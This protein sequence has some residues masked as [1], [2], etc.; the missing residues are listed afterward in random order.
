MIKTL[1]LALV[2]SIPSAAFAAGSDS[3]NDSPPAK[4]KTSKKCK[5]GKV[6]HKE[7]KSCLDA[8][9]DLL[10]DHIRYDAVR[11]LAYAGRY[12]QAQTVLAA[13]SD[14]KDTLVLTYYGFT[15]RKAGNIELGMSYYKEALAADPN[16]LLAR[17]YMGQGLVESGDKIGAKMQLAEI[18]KRG[19]EGR[20][21]EVSLARAIESGVGYSY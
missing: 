17:S 1:V 10:T 4:T 20:W 14:Q 16:N 13:M 21:P 2:L 3:S 11:E 9:S 7:T 8:K 6:W 19:G 5:D 18:R 15:N 12:A